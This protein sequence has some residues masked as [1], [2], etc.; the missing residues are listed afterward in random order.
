MRVDERQRER[1]DDGS[2]GRRAREELIE[3]EDAEL[4][5]R[6]GGPARVR[7]VSRGFSQMRVRRTHRSTARA[8]PIVSTRSLVSRK[9][10]VSAITIGYPWKS[11]ES[12]RTSR[13][14]PGISVTIAASRRARARTKAFEI[15][16]SM[17]SSVPISAE[18][19]AHL[20]NSG[21]SSCQRW[22]VRRWRGGSPNG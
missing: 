1:V 16:L 13:V 22:V 19:S 6:S 14:V 10:A 2:R 8:I 5:I 9:P 18:G 20:A 17:G 12:S 15:D 11:R 7:T 3:R 21:G 4:E